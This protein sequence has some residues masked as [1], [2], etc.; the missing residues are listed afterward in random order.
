M[1][2]FLEPVDNVVEYNR[3]GAIANASVGS[4]SGRDGVDD[5]T[6]AVA[7]LKAAL[8]ATETAIIKWIVAGQ[9]TTAG[10]V[11]CIARY[12]H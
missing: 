9:L 5:I 7:D 2:G 8:A 1:L 12:V 3:R 4:G 6:V 11:L 10:L